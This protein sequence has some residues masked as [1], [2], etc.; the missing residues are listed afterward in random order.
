[1]PNKKVQLEGELTI[2]CFN[3]DHITSW[4]YCLFPINIHSNGSTNCRESLSF[5]LDHTNIL[6]PRAII[7]SFTYAPS[8]S[9]SNILTSIAELILNGLTTL[10]GDS[11]GRVFQSLFPPMP[12]FKGRQVV[13]L[14]NQRDFLFFRRHRLVSPTQFL[15]LP[16]SLPLSPLGRSVGCEIQS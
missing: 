7:S 1:M 5:I 13:T 4:T 12:Q 2:R 8:S 15:L 16:F 9:P 14:H 10:L 6:G 3:F 11:V